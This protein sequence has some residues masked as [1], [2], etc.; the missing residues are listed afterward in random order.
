M[1]ISSPSPFASPFPG[2]QIK[3]GAP[4]LRRPSREEALSFPQEAERLLR[5]TWAAQMLCLKTG[6]FELEWIKDKHFLLAGATGAGLGGAIAAA[7]LNYLDSLG[8]LTVIARDPKRS[9]G[10]ETGQYML[11]KAEGKGKQDKFHWLNSGLSLEGERLEKIVAALKENGAGQVVYIN[12]VAAAVSGL[13]PGFPPVFVKDVDGEG[14][15]QWELVPLDERSIEVTQFTMGT[16]ATGFPQVLREAGI[17]VEAT[18]FTDWRGSFDRTSQEPLSPD[19]GR[20]GAYS[21]SLFLPKQ[22]IQ[23]AVSVAYGTNE[24]MIDIFLPVM[25]TH[26]LSMIPGGVAM[27]HL[28]QKIMQDQGV[29]PP[30]VPELALG[31]LDQLGKALT[32]KDK[33]PFPRLDAHEAPFDLWFIEIL[34]R[35]NQD[36]RSEFYYKKWISF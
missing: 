14:L 29:K 12:T 27:Y 34:K 13:L 26:A 35:L 9:L 2:L 21:T 22:I 3:Q 17:E 30:S 11:L 36:E 19:Y 18:A 25:N 31:V 8:S 24:V 4:A 6:S 23:Q 7:L 28:F 16:L 33:N 20:Q 5:E 1:T 10:F 15:F 32:G